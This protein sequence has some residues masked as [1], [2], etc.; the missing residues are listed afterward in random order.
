MG[1]KNNPIS[2]EEAEWKAES[3][4]QT[5]VD[6]HEIR[7]DKKR[8]VT[9]FKALRKKI[10]ESQETVELEKKVKTGLDATFGKSKG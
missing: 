9:A 1:C 10:K 6:A 7:A 2:T 8:F 3:D 4:A 5:L